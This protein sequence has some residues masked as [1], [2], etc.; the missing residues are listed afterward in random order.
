MAT[1]AMILV[2]SWRHSG[3]NPVTEVL[4]WKDTSSLGRISRGDEDIGTLHV[5]DQL[6]HMMFGVG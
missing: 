4:G 2:A 3:M 6:E 5:S 1:P